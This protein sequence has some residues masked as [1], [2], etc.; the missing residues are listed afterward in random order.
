MRKGEL[1]QVAEPQTLYDRP[2]N[3]FVGGFIGSPAMNMV[4]ATLARSNGGLAVNA[5]T[6]SIAL[7]H[8]TLAAHPALK[9]YEGRQ[10]VLGIR[11]E[12]LEDAALASD[13]P[14][15][16]RLHGTVGLTEALGSEIMVHFTV[17]ARQALTEDVR[18]LAQDVGDDRVEQ[19]LEEGVAPGATLVGRFGA[20]SRVREDDTIEIAV[21]TRALHFFDPESGAGIY[22][23]GPSTKGAAA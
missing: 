4:E 11:P 21:D 5:G 8:E 6:Q 2:V 19:Q 22:D 18:E 12:D 20:R 23:A 14:P 15:E 9:D 13:T 17:D 7:D 10:V 16:R 3:L 1:Q